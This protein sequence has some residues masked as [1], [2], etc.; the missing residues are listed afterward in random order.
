MSP[1]APCP[2]ECSQSI[3]AVRTQSAEDVPVT[4]PRSPLTPAWDEEAIRRLIGQLRQA[5]LTC[6][7]QD[8]QAP[9]ACDFPPESYDFM[10]PPL[11][12]DEMGRL[13]PYRVLDV[14]GM[15]GQGIVFLADDTQLQ[16]RVA[17]KTMRRTCADI[18]TARQRFLHEARS[19]ASLRHDNIVT[20]YHVGEEGGVPYLAMELLEGESLQNWLSKDRTPTLAQTLRIGKEIARGL[21]AAHAR[22]LI[23]RDIKPANIWL[24]ASAGGRVKLLDFGLARPTETS[25]QPTPDQALLGTLGYMA[26]EQ[27]AGRPTDPRADLFSL[28]VVLYRLLTGRLP[29]EGDV[30]RILAAL[31][32]EEPRPPRELN[33]QVPP[34]LSGLVVRLLAREPARRPESALAVAL[35]LEAMAAEQTQ[36]QAARSTR[37][38][39]WGRRLAV[40]SRARA[41]H[42]EEPR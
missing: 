34:A 21:A 4:V 1:L 41:G 19:S 8:L 3:A 17:L 27:A 13:G 37:L 32:T 31:A 14:L 30:L 22:G 7:T 9:S 24:D 10:I 25:T 12:P 28:G 20:V 11:R 40:A 15:G 2:H 35:E 23:H 36:K 18:P 26:P 5:P 6:D 33:G 42:R 38:S 39:R 29:F 16:R